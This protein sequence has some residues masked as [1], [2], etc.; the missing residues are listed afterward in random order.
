M[1]Q[2]LRLKV[3]VDTFLGI[4]RLVLTM[5]GLPYQRRI[6]LSYG[7]F[8]LIKMCSF[9]GQQCDIFND[10]KLHVDPAFVSFFQPWGSLLSI[11]P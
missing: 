5:A 8:E 4:F 6:F 10:F 11:F 9:N 3:L 1:Q 7:K 2:Y